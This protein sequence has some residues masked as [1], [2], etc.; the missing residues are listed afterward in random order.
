MSWLNKRLENQSYI[1]GKNGYVASAEDAIVFNALKQYPSILFKNYTND[2]DDD[3]DDAG[4]NNKTL[5][6]PFPHQC[7]Q[8]FHF[9]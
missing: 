3:S 6:R 2:D 7:F 4:Y 1:M 9:T 8:C 5:N